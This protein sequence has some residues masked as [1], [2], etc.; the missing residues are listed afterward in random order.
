MS[1]LLF[2]IE[3]KYVIISVFQVQVALL[4]ALLKKLYIRLGFE[5]WNAK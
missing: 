3:Q 2:F 5:L 4:L 1:E